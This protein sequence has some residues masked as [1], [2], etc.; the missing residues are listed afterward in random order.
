MMGLQWRQLV[1]AIRCPWPDPETAQAFETVRQHRTYQGVVALGL[2]QVVVLL[3][4]W[5]TDLALPGDVAL[6]IGLFR[7]G[8]LAVWA[9]AW[10]AARLSYFRRHADLVLIPFA[11][12]SGLAAAMLGDSTAF[13]APWIDVCILVPLFCIV[14]VH[15]F[16]VRVAATSGVSAGFLTLFLILRPEQLHNAHFG[17]FLISLIVATL[18]SVAVGHIYY[19]LLWQQFLRS[20]ALTAANEALEGLVQERTA[21]LAGLTRR[22]TVLHEE[23]RL[24][25]QRELSGQAEHFLTAS[26]AQLRE[27]TRDGG[28][29]AAAERMTELLATLELQIREVLEE[30]VASDTLSERIERTVGSAQPSTTAELRCELGPLPAL[31]TDVATSLYR[32]IQE[33]LTNA[34]KHGSATVI[35]VSA[36]AHGAG[37]RLSVVDDG[38]GLS[39]PGRERAGRSGIGLSSLRERAEELGAELTIEEGAEGGT[40]VVVF[41]VRDHSVSGLNRLNAG[42]ARE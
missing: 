13:D 12:A 23:E 37:V 15:P 25:V 16:W 35:T 14:L 10:M 27:M 19:Y 24:L 8:I 4:L 39:A 42:G 32:M 41:Y 40:R 3:G 7:V 34:L 26:A 5:P 29:S 20:R 2:A 6:K 11:L 18:A 21:E 9:L 17:S 1:G 30:E 33:A 31:A 28:D 22:L 38:V 36:Q